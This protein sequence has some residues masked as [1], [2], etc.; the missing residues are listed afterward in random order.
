M[1][2]SKSFIYLDLQK[3][4]TN[5]IVDFL[6]RFSSEGKGLRQKHRPAPVRNEGKFRFISVR[7]PLDQYV[8]LYSFGCGKRGALFQRLKKKGKKNLYARSPDSFHEWLQFVL[9]PANAAAL[10]PSYASV[11]QGRIC[12][13]IGFQSFRFLSLALS[14]PKQVFAECVTKQEII[15]AYRSQSAGLV[16][17]RHS[18]FVSDL[19]NL[20]ENPLGEAIADPRAALKFLDEAPA[21]NTSERIDKEDGLI[22]NSF[23]RELLQQR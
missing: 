20:V 11:G 14:D 1:Y 5:F 23:V 13:L 6:E 17:V 19:K 4:G 15:S 18:H 10:N 16:V 7:D 8:S 3:T 9:D 2:E 12:E 22:V 21:L